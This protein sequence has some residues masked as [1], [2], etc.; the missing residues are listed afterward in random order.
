MYTVTALS[1][2]TAALGTTM[3]AALQNDGD[4]DDVKVSFC[5]VTCIHE[6]F[7]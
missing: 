7:S 2:G 6:N 3:M 1:F 5:D 4:R